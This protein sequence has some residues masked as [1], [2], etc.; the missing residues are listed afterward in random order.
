MCNTGTKAPFSIAATFEGIFYKHQ[1][2]VLVRSV[3]VFGAVAAAAAA[4]GV[5]C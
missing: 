4:T 3:M 5:A 1:R 2:M